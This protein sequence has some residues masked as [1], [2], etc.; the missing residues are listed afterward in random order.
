M[1]I[2]EFQ[3]TKCQHQFEEILGQSGRLSPTYEPCPSC[4]F[5]AVV[6]MVSLTHVGDPVLMGRKKPPEALQRKLDAIKKTYSK[7][8]KS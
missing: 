3:C 4:G 6:P 7:F 2:F 1:P 8:Q 5:R